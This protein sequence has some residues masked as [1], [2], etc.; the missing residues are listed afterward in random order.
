VYNGRLPARIGTGGKPFR[1][2]L[3]V[4]AE[5]MENTLNSM[6]LPDISGV[7]FDSWYAST[8]YLEHIH[9]K[10]RKFFYSEIKSSLNL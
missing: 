1:Y 8:K 7:T 6:T 10:G 3:E 2:S 4:Y 5:V 9:S